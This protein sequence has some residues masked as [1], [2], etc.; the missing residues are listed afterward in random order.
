MVEH[1]IISIEIGALPRGIQLVLTVQHKAPRILLIELNE[2]NRDL[3][4]QVCER[5]D[6]P[7]ISRIIAFEQS[8]TFTDDE[9]DSGYLEP[10]VQW[11]SV[12]TGQPSSQHRIMHL[13]DVPDAS[14]KQIWETLSDAGIHSGIWGVMNGVRRGARNCDFFVA[15]PWTFVEDPHP[16][17]LLGLISFAR[18]IA[19]NYLNLSAIEVGRQSMIY[20]GALLENVSFRDLLAA[21]RILVEGLA[22]FGPKHHVLGAFFEYLSAIAFIKYKRQYQP[23]FSVIFFNLLAHLQHR[24]W[25]SNKE[26]SP[27]LLYGF[28]VV[29]QAL[30]Q[31][32][33][34]VSEDEILLVADALSQVNTLTEDLWILYRPHDPEGFVKA[35]GIECQQVEALMTYDAHVFFSDIA[36]CNSAFEIL[37]AASING[38]PLFYLDR[39]E[40]TSSKF[41]YRVDFTD[42]V[43]PDVMFEVGGRAYKFF[44]YFVEVGTRTGKHSQIGFV[45]QSKRIMPEQLHNHQI[46]DYIC[47]QLLPSFSNQSEAATA[48]SVSD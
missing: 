21:T 4:V 40:A 46:H 48:K 18:Y 2:V 26:L 13:G 17:N 5:I 39:G 6:L 47:A 19:K 37:R 30:G 16:T 32:F 41:F 27:H 38:K 23:Q 15:D 22:Q 3:L 28:K 10:W 43:S 14:V 44:D 20:L 36:Q 7:N 29:D 45:F 24:Y 11:V 31:V 34:S 8:R 42:V 9:Y 1:T 25:L 12:H 33:A 35:M